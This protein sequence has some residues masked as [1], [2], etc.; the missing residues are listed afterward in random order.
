MINAQA[1]QP[2]QIS[3]VERKRQS[4][5]KPINLH[6]EDGGW[7]CDGWELGGG[8]LRGLDVMIWPTKDGEQIVFTGK[9]TSIA[10]H[11]LSNAELWSLALTHVNETT[12][13]QYWGEDGSSF[14]VLPGEVL[15]DVYRS[16][17]KEE[18]DARIYVKLQQVKKILTEYGLPENFRKLAL[19]N[20]HDLEKT[21]CTAGYVPPENAGP[22]FSF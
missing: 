17:G 14:V 16:T 15:M 18:N 21:F 10:Q 22:I 4:N 2:L 5:L 3:Y 6:K 8:Y 7:Y 13:S 20:L 11:A 12:L 9:P 1:E 19:D